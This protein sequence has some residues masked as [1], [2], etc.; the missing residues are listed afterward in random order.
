M[1]SEALPDCDEVFSTY[2]APW[3]READLIDRRHVATRPDVE[4]WAKPNTPPERATLLNEDGRRRVLK[5]VAGMFEAA[6]GDWSTYLQVSG[7]PSLAW[8]EAFDA[9][10]TA[11][12]V[13]ELL[14][15]SDPADFSNDLL[16]TV[17]ELGAVLGHVLRDN[18][19]EFEWLP[20]WP[21]WESGLL[22]VPS[23]YRI[24]VF[25]WAI[26]RF[27]Q[28][29]LEDGYAAKVGMCIEQARAGWRA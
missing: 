8:I 1:S 29:G 24:N 4:S 18:R 21:Y 12:R 5:Q 20:D 10:W 28:Y 23:G 27:S 19:A 3:Y 14:D 9:Y 2:F 22:D 15:R 13:R 25:H 26:K 11:D 7:E 16:I 17:C 6:R